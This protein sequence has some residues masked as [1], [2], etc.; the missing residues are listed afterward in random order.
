[1]LQ[2][3]QAAPV[4]SGRFFWLSG[5]GYCTHRFPFQPLI[6]TSDQP[7]RRNRVGGTFPNP[8]VKTPPPPLSRAQCPCHRS[9][10]PGSQRGDKLSRTRYL[11]SRG[12]TCQS[13]AGRVSLG[14]SKSVP[15][16]GIPGI[17]Y[18]YSSKSLET[19][20]RK[21]REPGDTGVKKSPVCGDAN[22]ERPQDP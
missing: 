2:I 21:K 18:Y 1:M 8:S 11:R 10:A 4:V 14:A 12:V 13:A 19:V 5:L 22:K 17:I 6:N 15:H 3:C 20:G 16:R 9:P 7:L